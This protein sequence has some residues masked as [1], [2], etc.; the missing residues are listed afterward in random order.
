[1]SSQARIGTDA[2]EIGEGGPRGLDGGLDPLVGR[3]QLHVEALHVIQQLEGELIAGL[4][5]PA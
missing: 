5:R 1:M 4:L 2:I 3:L